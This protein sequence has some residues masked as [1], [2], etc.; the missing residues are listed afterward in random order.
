MNHPDQFQGPI[1]FMTKAWIP[2]W[3]ITVSRGAEVVGMPYDTSLRDADD[4]NDWDLNDN[5]SFGC[6]DDYDDDDDDDD[7]DFSSFPIQPQYQDTV[8]GYCICCRRCAR[9]RKNV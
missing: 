1:S 5:N 9:P 8:N 7:A 3:I 2:P 6:D 4:D